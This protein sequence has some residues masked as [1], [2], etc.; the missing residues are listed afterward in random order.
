MRDKA[1][2]AGSPRAHGMLRR[3]LMQ[4]EH[5]RASEPILAVGREHDE[6][7]ELVSVRALAF[8]EHAADGADRGQGGDE[9]EEKVCRGVVRA[10]NRNRKQMCVLDVCN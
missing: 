5:Q 6:A 10:W 7:A 9:A 4:R 8:R 1:D 3:P 2:G